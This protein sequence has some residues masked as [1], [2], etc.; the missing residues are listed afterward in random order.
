MTYQADIE[1]AALPSAS[2]IILDLC[3]GSG[4]WSK[5][6]R[7]AGYDVR[8]VT[9][10]ENDVRLYTPP[11]NVHGILAAPPCTE[12]SIA[13]NYHGGGHDFI[14]GLEIVSACM[15][16]ILTAKPVWWAIENPRGYLQRWLGKP[17]FTFDPWQFGDSYQKKTCLWGDF[18]LPMPAVKEKPQC[19]VKFALLKTREICP[20]QYGKLSRQERRAITPPG[21]AR[22]FFLANS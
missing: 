16:I 22:A 12:F 5:P 8:L 17:A 7:D 10:P 18:N 15:R 4:A 11:A 14:A 19:L 6:Y 2:R 21:F 9:L 3:A 1:F 20:A 13:R